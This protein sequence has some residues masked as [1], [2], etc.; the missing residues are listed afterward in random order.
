MILLCLGKNGLV[1]PALKHGQNK[2]RQYFCTC[3]LLCL[4]W[5]LLL[6]LIWYYIHKVESN[7][8]SLNA[9]V[10]WN[11]KFKHTFGLLGDKICESYHKHTK[12]KLS[13]PL[14]YVYWDLLLTKFKSIACTD[15]KPRSIRIGKS[16]TPIQ[17]HI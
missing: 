1:Y 9:S 13:H 6:C 4:I 2:C 17:S 7:G 15:L 5:S 10:I 3:L 8:S 14:S 16:E 12:L 11:P